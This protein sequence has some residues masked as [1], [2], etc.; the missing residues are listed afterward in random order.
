MLKI[1]LSENSQ[2]TRQKPA[3]IPSP[4]SRPKS[5]AAA[6][7]RPEPKPKA[8]PAASV[9]PRQ[10]GR[11]IWTG[12]AVVFLLAIFGAGI[13][14][15]WDSFAAF[16]AGGPEAPLP[17][18]VVPISTPAPAPA[19]VVQAPAP[20][21]V[22]ALLSTLSEIIP[23]RVWL[24]NLILRFDGSYELQGMAFAYPVMAVLDSALVS[25]GT[26]TS[27]AYP[28]RSS[29]AETIYRFTVSG[30]AKGFTVPDIL[31]LI[32]ADT[33]AA[34]AAPV[35]KTSGQ[36]GV[37]FA[38]APQPGRTYREQDLP[39]S[40]VGSFAAV[41]QVIGGLCANDADIR[42]YQLEITPS[43]I[44]R[45]YDQVRARFSLRTKSSI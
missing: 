44:G 7:P 1:N 14:L 20:E 21:P 8:K 10:R 28:P 31:D 34:Y 36:T 9:P 15:S 18:A 3:D 33:L 41:Q 25:L 37:T 24:T 42:V 26:V 40:L 16:F 5:E 6:A 19:A 43:E 38:G 22:F 2:D 11:G 32:P 29:S 17:Q 13:Y 39:F 30:K 12:F 35:I 4:D 27:R 45:P 23:P